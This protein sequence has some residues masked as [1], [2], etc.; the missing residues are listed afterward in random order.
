MRYLL[1]PQGAIPLEMWAGQYFE[2]HELEFMLSVLGPGMTFVDVGANVGL[3]SIPAAMK[4]RSGIVFAFEP[5]SSTYD[6]LVKN[7]RL[8]KLSNVRAVR[9]ALADCVGEAA[10]H[11]NVLGK[12]GL[13]TLGKP[14]HPQCEIVR[15][16]TVR[17]TTLDAFLGENGI[18]HVDAIKIDAEGAEPIVLR[19]ATQLLAR[20]DAPL[21]LFECGRL[22]AGFGYHPVESVWLLQDLGYSL[23]TLNSNDGTLSI[24]FL[25][26]SQ[27]Y[28]MAIAIKPT[29][30]FY[31]ALMGRGR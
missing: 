29:H 14:T 2:R 24:P 21:I 22:S 19:G 9:S 16:E 11:V 3:Y 4:V 18:T 30:P 17:T 25:N 5:S 15:K 10:L 12:D 13:N 8:N 31:P 20:P 6:Q 1:S 26:Q 23:F 27:L 28:D 7:V